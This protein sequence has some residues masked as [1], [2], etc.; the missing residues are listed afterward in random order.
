M[1][2]LT[3]IATTCIIIGLTILGGSWI[4]A[5]TSA[6]A[7]PQAL[8]RATIFGADIGINTEPARVLHNGAV[9]LWIYDASLEDARP[10]LRLPGSP[11]PAIEPSRPPAAPAPPARELKWI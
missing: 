8:L 11:A 2:P 7:R 6:S 9:E 4:D 3:I 1:R 10:L 5:A